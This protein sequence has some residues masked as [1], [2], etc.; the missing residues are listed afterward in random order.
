MSKY[1]EVAV[2]M[3]DQKFSVV[4]VSDNLENEKLFYSSR[5]IQDTYQKAFE[6]VELLRTYQALMD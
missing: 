1:K 2:Y 4:F 5:N 6:A 3:I